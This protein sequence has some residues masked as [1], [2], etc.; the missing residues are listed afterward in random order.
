[1]IAEVILRFRWHLLVFSG[2]A[3]DAA[4]LAPRVLAGADHAE[5]AA[6]P[7][8]RP[9]AGRR[10]DRVRRARA[11][12]ACSSTRPGPRAAVAERPRLVQLRRVHGDGVGVVGR[13][14]GRRPVA[15]ARPLA[16]PRRRQRPQRRAARRRRRR[17]RRP[18][19][20]RRPGDSHDRGV[21]RAVPARRPLHRHL[22]APVPRRP[23]RLLGGG[24]AVVGRAPARPGPA[25]ATATSPAPLL[26]ARDGAFTA[27]GELPPPADVFT[28]LPLPW[29]VE[30]AVRADAAGHDGGRAAGPVARRPARARRPRRA[31]PARPASAEPAVAQAARRLLGVITLP[32]GETTRIE[33]LGPLRTARRRRGRSSG[34]SSAGPASASCSPC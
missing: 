5:R 23:L 12:P 21:R 6:V 1:M 30:L 27:R 32:P 31:A 15:A 8:R 22:P 2:R 18:R 9:L 29:S 19:P 10:P 33:V 26:A 34:P 13:P 7:A 17:R 11:R 16:R 28:A 20:R 25:C 24:P 3:E 4:R 14:G